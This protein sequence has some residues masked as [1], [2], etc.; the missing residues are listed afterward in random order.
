MVGRRAYL[1]HYYDVPGFHSGTRGNRTHGY[2]FTPQVLQCTSGWDYLLV[3][4]G[5][6]WENSPS[7][8]A[9]KW[10]AEFEE[11]R[12]RGGGTGNYPII[13]LP[14]HRLVTE[15]LGPPVN[16]LHG[17]S[18]F[19]HQQ[20]QECSPPTPSLQQ[21][22]LKV[23]TRDLQRHPGEPRPGTYIK[24]PRSL[25]EWIRSQTCQGIEKVDTDDLLRPADT[26]KIEPG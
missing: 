14:P 16:H 2:H 17:K 19:G 23:R 5:A 11:E 10:H 22:Q 7:P 8:D 1:L 3:G 26:G 20:I 25:G 21:G 6:L 9:H 15:N 13:A 12:K 18:K 24:E 4:V